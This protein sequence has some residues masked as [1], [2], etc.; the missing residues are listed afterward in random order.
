MDRET[1][2]E[3][4]QDREDTPGVVTENE[5]VNTNTISTLESITALSINPEHLKLPEWDYTDIVTDMLKYFAKEVLVFEHPDSSFF[6]QAVSAYRIMCMLII[7][8]PYI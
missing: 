3:S 8:C 5:I 2:L 6:H 7:R 4:L 1:P